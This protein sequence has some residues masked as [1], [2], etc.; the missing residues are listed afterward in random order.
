MNFSLADTLLLLPGII[1]GLTVHEFTHAYTA[2]KLGDNT[3]K[4]AGRLTL[5]PLS[6]IDPLGFIM[7]ILFRFGWAKPVPFNSVNFKQPSIDSVK[8]ALMGPVSNI[9]L[10]LVFVMIMKVYAVEVTPFIANENVA[11]AI[12]Q[13]L[14]YAVKINIALFVFNFLPIPPLDGS[15]LLMHVLPESMGE[16]KTAIMK[17]GAFLIVIILIAQNVFNMNILPIWGITNSI[18]EFFKSVL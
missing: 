11:G 14:N 17:Y 13:I 2:Y 15:Y 4:N 1:V 18:Y 12:L 5:N 10:A 9:L 6:H 3:A 8:V 16:M 7:L